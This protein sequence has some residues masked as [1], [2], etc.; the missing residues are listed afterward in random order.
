MVAYL[1]DQTAD[2]IDEGRDYPGDDS[3][4]AGGKGC[5]APGARLVLD[6]RD[7]GYAGEVK[8]YKYK[9]RVGDERSNALGEHHLAQVGIALAVVAELLF[10]GE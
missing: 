2:L 10:V 7:G 5:P 9:V 1:Q 6:G 3:G 8:Q 4:I